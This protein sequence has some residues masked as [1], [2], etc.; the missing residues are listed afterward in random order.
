MQTDL[1]L[2]FHQ[3]SK[4]LSGVIPVNSDPKKWPKEWH[5]VYYKSYPRMPMVSLDSELKIDLSRGFF[6]LLLNRQTDRK[7]TSEAVTIE[8][9]SYL[10]RFSC[11]N[12]RL[13]KDGGKMLRVYPSAGSRYPI[14]IYALVV[15]SS[16]SLK[17]GLYH[18][19]VKNHL[20]ENI[21]DK[22]FSLNPEELKEYFGSVNGWVSDTG[23]IFF[24]TAV[25]YRNQMKYGERGYRY[26]LIEAGHIGQNLYLV[27]EAL[28]LKCCALGGTRDKKIEELLDIDGV[29]E[30]LVYAVAVGK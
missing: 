25:F 2:P 21:W 3:S 5:T 11:G 8:D 30:S 12:S 1:S 7:F 10:L 17:S 9:L 28:G 27:S 6:E 14:E 19:H 29:N 16:P 24:M 4:D 13:A 22:D 18:Y 15:H 26:V 23:I 20:L